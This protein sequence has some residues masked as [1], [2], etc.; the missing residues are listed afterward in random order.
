VK[1][2]ALALCCASACATVARAPQ[3]PSSIAVPGSLLRIVAEKASERD[4]LP[5]LAEQV[6]QALPIVARW[7]G[8]R[9]PTQITVLQDHAELERRT[10]QVGYGWLRAWARYDRIYVQAP[11]TWL[12]LFRPS[13]RE[14]RE[15]L[16]HELT[17]CVMYQ[18]I[19]DGHDWAQIQ[20]PLWFREG[21]A[22][23]TAQ[24]TD[25]R[26]PIEDLHRFLVEHPNLDPLRQADHMVR[27]NSGLV[28][29]AAHW[30]FGQLSARGT[31]R[32]VNLLGNLRGGLPFP[33]AFAAAFGESEDDFENQVLSAWRAYP[34]VCR[35]KRFRLP[36]T[37]PAA[38]PGDGL[39]KLVEASAVIGTDACACLSHSCR[40]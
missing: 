3:G 20:V 25:K 19:S 14:I 13:A 2:A 30:A 21:L 28:Y 4:E 8:L 16:T 32:V 39:R 1:R 9:V 29:S 23:W 6:A 35:G 31:S 26:F 17:H 34:A 24:E 10:G 37:V 38:V 22:S 11:S 7:G 40:R 15:L 5:V 12:F 33:Q 18:A 36:P 27:D